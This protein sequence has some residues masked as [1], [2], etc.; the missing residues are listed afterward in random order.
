MISAYCVTGIIYA[1]FWEIFFCKKRE[2]FPTYSKAELFLFYLFSRVLPV[3]VLPDNQKAIWNNL[4]VEWLVIA[5]LIYYVKNRKKE[6]RRSGII[7]IYLFQPLSILLILSGRHGAS[8]IALPVLVF[9]CFCDDI[10]GK[11]GRSLTEFLPEYVLFHLGLFFWFVSSELLEQSFSQITDTENIPVLYIVSVVIMAV[12]LLKTIYKMLMKPGTDFSP[13]EGTTNSVKEDT[14]CERKPG[15]VFRSENAQPIMVRDILL[16]GLFTLLFAGAVFYGLGS[17]RVPET[18]QE[19]SVGETGK[20]QIVLNFNQDTEL[21][22][23]YIF[24]G[25]Q[26]K[27]KIS[28]SSRESVEDEWEVF[29]GNQNVESAFCWNEVVIDRSLS[30][31]GM[32]LMEGNARIH[33]IICIDKNGYRVMPQNA[34]S[35]SRLFDEQALFPAERTYYYRTMF[36][37]VYH[38]RTAY[39]FLN[40]L[41]IYENTHPPLGKTIISLGIKA[42]GMNPFGWRVMCALLGTLMVPVMYLFAHSMF[43][44][45]K[46]SSFTTLLLCTE[47]MH[48]AL[49][50]IAT[51]DI[52]V[53]FFVLLMFFF[54]Y[55]FVRN[56]GSEKPFGKQVGY[57]L[58]AGVAT[59]FAV[60]T[61]WTGCYAAVGLAV[62]FFVFLWENLKSTGGIKK[63]K[64]YLLRLCVCCVICFIVIP[65]T[66]YLLSYIPFTKVYTDKNL[67]E[68]ALENGKLMLGYHSETVFEHPYS[69][70]WYQ[71]ILDIRPLLDTHTVLAEGKISAVATFGNPLLWWGGLLAFFHQ[72]YLWRCE[73]CKNARYLVISYVSIVLPWLFIHRTVFIYQYFL[74]SILLL[75]MIA[76]SMLH[77]KKRERSMIIFSIVSVILFVMFYPVL[78]GTAV[79]ADYVNR[80]LEWLRTWQFAL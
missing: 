7:A 62:L 69:S 5:F 37:E 14:A 29:A 48:F 50:R 34:M 77:F 70:E 10:A 30:S 47:F 23:I 57:L 63:N 13:V 16:M 12:A 60:S 36:D 59:A 55:G 6:A 67:W 73:N 66:V 17:F 64:T 45:T 22:R 49:S 53:A 80:V 42:F 43:G 38:A 71:W 39:E 44:T 25:Y 15:R 26:S 79:S 54:M 9:F 28:F 19:L 61:K 56:G 58:G 74:G 52:L 4:M 35:Y 2:N 72:F 20:N 3:A 76:N 27:R 75:P 31:L 46:A 24:L 11:K 51:L 68:T 78:S 32:V 18:Y 1:I 8:L 65:G 40:Q 33:E 21:S 41:S